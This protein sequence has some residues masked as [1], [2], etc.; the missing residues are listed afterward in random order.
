MKN[1]CPIIALISFLIIGSCVTSQKVPT[2][3]LYESAWELEYLSEPDTDFAELF[4][5]K[6]PKIEFKKDSKRAEGNSGCNGYGAEFNLVGANITFG[7]PGP[8]TMMYCGEGEKF[9]R[10]AMAKVNSFE[11]GENDKL[12]LKLDDKV[13]MRFKR[14]EP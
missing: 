8:S 11:F 3:K 9:F 10:N 12:V 14:V 13:L 7:E 4:P 1:I 5:S 6:N 2:E